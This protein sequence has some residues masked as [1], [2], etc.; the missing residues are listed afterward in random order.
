M[1]VDGRQVVVADEIR[2]TGSAADLPDELPGGGE[3]GDGQ[4]LL[5]GDVD[6]ARLAGNQVGCLQ[7]LS[8]PAA[9]A[10]ELADE[11]PCGVN[12]WTRLLPLSATYT[13]PPG[14]TA[15]FPWI[16]VGVVGSKAMN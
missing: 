1:R 10:A 15:I 4:S 12:T 7:E 11:P 6:V 14:P 9:E 2:V 5:V 8:L 3:L 16:S 13:K